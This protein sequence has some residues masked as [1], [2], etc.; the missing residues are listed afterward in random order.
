MGKYSHTRENG[1]TEQKKPYGMIP[2]TTY[3][4]FCYI[5]SSDSL[6]TTTFYSN[7]IEH[8]ASGYDNED[9]RRR[10]FGNKHAH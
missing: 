8:K 9:N 6:F 10:K 4:K 7:E 3:C 2:K 1:K 5:K